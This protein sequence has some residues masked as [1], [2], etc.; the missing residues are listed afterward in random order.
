MLLQFDTVYR[1]NAQLI[2]TRELTGT[3]DLE[4]RSQQV[5]IVQEFNARLVGRENQ[6]FTL[7][8]KQK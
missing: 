7:K 1:L 2:L 8:T 3:R 5:A 4:F 6:L